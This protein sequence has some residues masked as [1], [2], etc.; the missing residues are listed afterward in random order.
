[1]N[2]EK[3]VSNVYDTVSVLLPNYKKYIT[4]ENIIKNKQK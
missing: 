3:N 4:K 1:M 2:G